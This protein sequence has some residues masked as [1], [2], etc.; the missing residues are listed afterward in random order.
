MRFL[1][2][3]DPAGPLLVLVHGGGVGPWMWARQLSG[4]ADGFHVVAPVLPGHDPEEASVFTTHGDASGRLAELIGPRRNGLPVT[5][6]GFSLG[7]QTALQ[8]A[9][10]HPHLVDRLVV[11]SSLAAPYPLAPLMRPLMVAAA[12]LVRCRAFARAQAR[13]LSIPPELFGDY[14]RTARSISP[15]SLSNIAAA[16]FRFRVPAVLPASPRPT[17]LLAGAR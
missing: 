12:P 7:G 2:A 5:V 13:Q 6:A 10:D 3:G 1:E 8:L 9:A 11:V 16:N 15:V 4:L 17:L 14:D